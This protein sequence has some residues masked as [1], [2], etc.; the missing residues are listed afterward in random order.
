ME[1]EYP[2][3]DRTREPEHDVYVCHLCVVSW[4]GS[5]V[6]GTTSCPVCGDDFDFREKSA[7]TMSLAQEI[8]EEMSIEDIEGGGTFAVTLESHNLLFHEDDPC[9]TRSLRKLKMK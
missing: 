1:I 4:R 2:L 5:P 7:E 6:D 8:M 3:L 9:L